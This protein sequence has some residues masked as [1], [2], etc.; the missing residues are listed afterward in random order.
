MVFTDL[1]QCRESRYQLRHIER[2]PFFADEDFALSISGTLA[3]VCR[4][5]VV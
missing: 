1:T 2:R 4:G 3:S 5:E